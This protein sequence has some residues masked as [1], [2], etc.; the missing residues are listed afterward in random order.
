M[1]GLTNPFSDRP[2][3][4]WAHADK[5]D[6]ANNMN[7]TEVLEEWIGEAGRMDSGS[8][9]AAVVTRELFAELVRQQESD[10]PTVAGLPVLVAASEVPVS[11][12]AVSLDERVEISGPDRVCVYVGRGPG[13]SSFPL[14][15]DPAMPVFLVPVP[16]ATLA[17]G[18]ELEMYN[19]LRWI[20][21]GPDDALAGCGH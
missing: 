11:T 6:E 8:A 21:L 20:G 13:E 7:L 4:E 15:Y 3:A 19:R 12:D 17:D 14:G 16:P 1:G 18:A 9:C 10:A 2:G 5:N